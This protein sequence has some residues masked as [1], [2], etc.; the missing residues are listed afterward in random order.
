MEVFEYMVEN[1][2]YILEKLWQHFYIFLI[3]WALAIVAGILLGIFVT[4]SGKEKIGKVV[5]SISG[6]AQAIPSIAII[7][8]IFVFLGIGALPAMVALFIYS[9]V[10]IV[11]NSAS[12]LLNVDPAVKESARGMGMSNSQ[13][14]RKVEL[15]LVI[16]TVF[17]GIRTAAIINIGTAAIAATIGAGGLGEIILLG[18]RMMSYTRILAGAIP[19][20]LLAIVVDI[21]L[22]RLQKRIISPGLKI[23]QEGRSF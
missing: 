23:L 11:F 12:G 22:A 1:W 17:S 19:V 21:I 14:L 18:L 5:L 16:P 3:S 13:I 6:A 10:P 9:L 7:A 4:R 2:S 8:L 15:P 20:T